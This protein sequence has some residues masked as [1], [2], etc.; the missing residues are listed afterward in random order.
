MYEDSDAVMMM[1]IMKLWKDR[2][3]G[4]LQ[5]LLDSELRRSIYE[6][7]MYRDMRFLRRIVT[8]MK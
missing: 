2:K 8:C 4:N 3:W 1:R 5:L 6:R 7:D